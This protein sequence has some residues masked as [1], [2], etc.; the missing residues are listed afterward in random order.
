MKEKKYT[1]QNTF[2]Y[3]S[4]L[5]VIFIGLTWIKRNRKKKQIH[6]NYHHSSPHIVCNQSYSWK[7]SA[8]NIPNDLATY[9]AIQPSPT[10]LNKKTNWSKGTKPFRGERKIEPQRQ[11]LL[12][13]YASKTQTNIWITTFKCIHTKQ[14]IHKYG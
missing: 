1:D 11:L 7:V 13:A 6:Y 14:Q 9:H 12:H 2:S 10:N 4:I 5:F 8:V 3:R